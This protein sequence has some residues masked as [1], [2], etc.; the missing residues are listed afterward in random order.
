MSV[1]ITTITTITTRLQEIWERYY[2]L[3]M[4]GSTLIVVVSVIVL[5]YWA[6]FL[7]W[8][9]PPPPPHTP[10]RDIKEL[11]LDVEDSILHVKDS[12]EHVITHQVD[13]WETYFDKELAH[14]PKI[15]PY[16]ELFMNVGRFFY[17]HRDMLT[18]FFVMA[19]LAITLRANYIV[20]I[21]QRYEENR[22]TEML[23]LL[24]RL[25]ERDQ[26]KK[27]KKEKKERHSLNAN[28]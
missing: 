7:S 25:D 6:V 18:L 16:H 23:L 10:F 9:L 26:K 17:Y 8:A 20:D 27:K 2:W 24:K 21:N 28:S 12:I 22:I 3:R 19:L 4:I 5:Y 14:H 1:T 15:N 13:P 11:I